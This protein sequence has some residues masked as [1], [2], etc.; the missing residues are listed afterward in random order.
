MFQMAD[1]PP[2]FG[3]YETDALLGSGGSSI[4]L[5]CVHRITHEAVAVKFPKS[6]AI[7]E[8]QAIRREVGVLRH[9]ERGL[10]RGVV[11]VRAD[12]EVDGLPWYAMELIEG[13]TLSEAHEAVRAAGVEA[14]LHIG[15][16]LAEALTAVHGAGVIHGDLTPHNILLREG[17]DAVMIDFGASQLQVGAAA[18]KEVPLS[19]GKR[20]GTPS[21]V[22]P[23]VIHGLPA[24]SRS[25]LYS[26]G[27]I[28]YTTLTGH[29]PFAGDTA[30]AVL[31]QQLH[32]EPRAPTELN[33]E[34]SSELERVILDLLRRSPDQRTNRASE[35]CVA[36]RAALG[37]S[38]PARAEPHPPP[39]FHPRLRGREQAM[40]AL[41]GAI[42][43]SRLGQGG[44]VVLSGPSGI[45]KTRILNEVATHCARSGIPFIWAR[46]SAVAGSAPFA[47]F[48]PLLDH[49]LATA[50]ANGGG[51]AG[52]MVDALSDLKPLLPQLPEWIPA[53][54]VPGADAVPRGLAGLY[55]LLLHVNGTEGLIVLLDDAQDADELTLAFLA[56]HAKDLLNTR[57]LIVAGRREE[58]ATRQT[59]QAPAE[60]LLIELEPLTPSDVMDVAKDILGAELPPEG[61]AEFLYAN[62]DGNPFFAL[63]YSRAALTQGMLQLSARNE[64]AFPARW[65]QQ[66]FGIPSNIEGLL[67]LRLASLTPAARAAL[68]FVAILGREFRAEA[69]ESLVPDR[70]E[71]AALLEELV[72]QQILLRL[73]S[74]VF[75]FAHDKLREAQLSLLSPEERRAQHRKVVEYVQASALHA[76]ERHA[77]LGVHL[78]ASG[79]AALAIEHLTLAARAAHAAYAFGRATELYGLALEQCEL[80]P[81]ESGA[82]QV[83]IA[84]ALADVLLKQARH[85]EARARL[86]RALAY[87]ASLNKLE[88]ARI[89]RKLA[90]S[91]WTLHEYAN[92]DE[93]L[94]AAEAAL[95]SEL[96]AAGYQEL[97]QIRLGRFEQLYFS[98]RTGPAL[99]QVVS[100]LSP[101]IERHGS[102]DQACVYYF[103]AASYLSLRARYAFDSEA[104]RLAEQGLSAASELS[105]HRRALANF[106]VGGTL[107]LGTIGQCKQAGSY[108][109][110][111]MTLASAAGETTLLSRIHAFQT[112][113]LLR[114]G[115]VAETERQ[116]RAALASAES[117]RLPPYIAAAYACQGWV[118]L[119]RGD[120]GRARELLELARRR[121]EEHPHKFPFTSLGLYSLLALAQANDDFEHAQTLLREI[122]RGLPAMSKELNEGLEN[123]LQAL[124]R[125][126]PLESARAITE[127]IRLARAAGYL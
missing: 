100:E 88:C 47:A 72:A 103:T 41:F 52:G 29:A 97:V 53:P 5:R 35:V 6:D 50:E 83:V 40:R 67:R 8:V 127:V 24:D 9:L 3:E 68:R 66:S 37:D 1:Y 12:G 58:L 113:A 22:A 51:R 96:D 30:D 33:R 2:A 61:L 92:A 36:L 114:Q 18:F 34:I 119:R 54:V 14:V 38:R 116:A 27:A 74:G 123:A 39:L 42:D 87:S 106:M 69:F 77:A 71:A 101:L 26:L 4:V 60:R 124:A 104:L 46:V 126:D 49:A 45:G 107:V 105:E 91:H 125:V 63:E 56:A 13:P 62:S 7:D 43:S 11:R 109:Q 84:E 28:L 86:H 115:D 81:S 102:K 25:D 70:G 120:E 79:D 90:S 78:A 57:V 108:L 76:D 10:V 17:H 122:R 80:L 64:W 89:W 65:A 98:G 16:A 31:Q 44:L 32:G 110:R 117:A 15:L 99:D 85:A 59:A 48:R 118:A 111:A 95:G 112:I 75:R 20:M 82:Q 55:R 94:T 93:A 121:F 23:E 21:F 73:A 19:S